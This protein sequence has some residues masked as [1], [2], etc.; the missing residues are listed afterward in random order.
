MN[1]KTLIKLT[2]KKLKMSRA[3]TKIVVD[4]FLNEIKTC[5]PEEKEI[6]IEGLGTLYCTKSK[7]LIAR[8]PVKGTPL[9]IPEKNI[10]RFRMSKKLKKELNPNL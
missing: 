9:E 3:P 10:I 4:A 2:A 8:H 6:R 7:K 1:V 5:F